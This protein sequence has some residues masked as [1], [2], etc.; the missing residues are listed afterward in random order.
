MDV[1]EMILKLQILTILAACDG[2]SPLGEWSCCA[3]FLKYVGA[4]WVLKMVAFIMET[5]FALEYVTLSSGMHH[6][7]YGK[8]R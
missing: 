5:A 8:P 6:R 2:F 4:A 7:I 3:Y 1:R